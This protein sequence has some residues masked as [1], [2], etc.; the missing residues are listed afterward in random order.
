MKSIPRLEEPSHTPLLAI[1]G[2]PPDMTAPPSGCKFVSRCPY[3]Q[4]RCLQEE[5]PLHTDETVSSDH[6][7]ACWYPRGTA[8]GDRVAA[9]NVD[10]AIR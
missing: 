3:A 9:G 7:F 8:T 1:S 2:R 5:P 10:G 4:P 6:A